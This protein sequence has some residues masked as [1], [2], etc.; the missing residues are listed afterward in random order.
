MMPA[1]SNRL[2]RDG[3]SDRTPPLAEANQPIGV[4]DMVQHRIPD[5]HYQVF[6]SS[7][8]KDLEAHRAQAVL[9][10][11][12]AG[13]MPVALE[14]SPP[15]PATK[16]EVIERAIDAS[17]FYVIILGAR[18]GSLIG[19]DAS[20]GSKSYVE[21]EYEYAISK[22]KRVLAFVADESTLEF[23]RR[24]RASKGKT[25]V[26]RPKHYRRFRDRL[27]KGAD[28]I[29]HSQ[30]VSPS[31]IRENLVAFFARPHDDVRGYVLELPA[32]ERELLQIYA[33]NEVIRDVVRGLDKFQGV[34][35]RLAVAAAK[36]KALADAFNDMYGEYL[37][38]VHLSR[39]FLESGSTVTYVAKAIAASLPKTAGHRSGSDA[40]SVL[41]NNAFAYLYL[42]LCERVFCQPIPQGPPDEKYGGMYG[43]LNAR[44]RQP[45]Y[46]GRPLAELD[47]DSLAILEAFT[48]ATFGGPE[49]DRALILGAASG[50]QLGS[51]ARV[52]E[53][54]GEDCVHTETVKSIQQLRGFHGGSYRNKLFKRAVYATNIPSIVFI[55]DHKI[56]CPIVAGKCHFGF[57][58]RADWSRFL[59]SNPVALWVG[60]DRSS[61]PRVLAKLKKG[62][63][64]DW[65]HKPYGPSSRHPVVMSSGPRF[66]QAMADRGI[67]TEV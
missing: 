40:L 3:R 55:H 34:E 66:R 58:S 10:V 18:Y 5:R 56:D 46:S 32:K 7:T 13:H 11:V 54:N 12:S 67:R 47:P 16:R 4:L 48:A 26:D 36:K 45:D 15:D 9:G 43:P 22:R 49:W 64:A 42:W 60:C 59:S 31:T 52:V 51:H 38:A 57:D 23:T 30:F 65:L 21:M 8:F 61:H 1:R 20:K 41:T 63:P 50:L 53:P 37:R 35:P 29:F 24:R 27:T 19:N 17:Q 39:V 62:L 14:N 25:V 2:R 6:I 44:Y 33:K 28:T